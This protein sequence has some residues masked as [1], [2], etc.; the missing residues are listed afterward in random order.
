MSYSSP[1]IL[2]DEERE[3]KRLINRGQVDAAITM[4]RSKRS[5]SPRVLGNIA[6]LYAENKGDYDMAANFYKQMLAVQEKVDNYSVYIDLC[7][8]YQ[9]FLIPFKFLTKNSSVS[10]V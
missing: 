4:F 2:T 9:R 8:L 5:Q 10:D 1:R 7:L 3:A 6:Q